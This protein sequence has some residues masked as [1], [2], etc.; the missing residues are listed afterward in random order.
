MKNG[1]ESPPCTAARAITRYRYGG[2]SGELVLDAYTN[3]QWQR[4]SIGQAWNSS[5]SS[6]TGAATEHDSYQAIAYKSADAQGWRLPSLT[7]LRSVM[8]YCTATPVD[9]EFCNSDAAK[10]HQGAF[11]NTPIARNFHAAST[12]DGMTDVYQKLN[13]GS[14]YAIASTMSTAS[15][16]YVRLVRTV[17]P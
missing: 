2:T 15:R 13:F 8:Y 12:L 4:C 17:T 16:N 9:Y 6:C 14:G 10:I 1:L 3:L 11:P 7:E 5:S